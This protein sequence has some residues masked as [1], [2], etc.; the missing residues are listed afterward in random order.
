MY[1]SSITAEWIW[2]KARRPVPD[3]AS[4]ILLRIVP[5]VLFGSHYLK[6]FRKRLIEELL[7]DRRC[8]VSFERPFFKWYAYS[9]LP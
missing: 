1:I 8:A 9:D 3:T 4:R 5:G 7:R 6:L 2:L